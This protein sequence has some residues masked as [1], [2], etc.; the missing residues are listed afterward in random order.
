MLIKKID[1]R[2]SL[3]FLKRGELRHLTPEMMIEEMQSFSNYATLKAVPVTIKHLLHMGFQ[4]E[5]SVLLAQYKEK[6]LFVEF[7][8]I[9]NEKGAIIGFEL[10]DV[11]LPPPQYLHHIQ[12]LCWEITH[13]IMYYRGVF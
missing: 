11:P 10:N 9:L 4:R 7:K 5:G 6:E 2:I 3:L 12:G 8:Y 13:K 1:L